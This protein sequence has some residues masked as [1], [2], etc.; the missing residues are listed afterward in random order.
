MS[1]GECFDHS[2]GSFHTKTE[3]PRASV[4]EDDFLREPVSRQAVGVGKGWARTQTQFRKLQTTG[5]FLQFQWEEKE[6]TFGPT[7]ASE[8]STSG[9]VTL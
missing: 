2:C 5:S 6:P 7:T 3:K 4:V 1:V 8:S 9:S